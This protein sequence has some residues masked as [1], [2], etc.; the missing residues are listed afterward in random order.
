MD[1]KA[2]EKEFEKHIRQQ[3]EE[4]DKQQN[5]IEGILYDLNILGEFSLE[6]ELNK[7]IIA[8]T[9][10]KL[11]KK[12]RRKV[13]DNHVLFVNVSTYGTYQKIQIPPK[14][15]KKA[16]IEKVPAG[17]LI[18]TEQPIIVLNFYAMKKQSKSKKMSTVAHEIAHFIL[19]HDKPTDIS[20]FKVQEKKADDLVVRWG[21]KR[22]YKSYSVFDKRIK[23][24]EIK[25]QDFCSIRLIVP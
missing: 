15:I 14:L 18:K 24:S 23:N 12:I 2:E 19:G 4:F 3:Q 16:S 9:L 20:Y 22:A 1:K 17:F 5:S 11:P 6:D 7:K 25:G 21:F 13:L 8:E 10:Q